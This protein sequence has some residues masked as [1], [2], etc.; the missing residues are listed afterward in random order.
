MQYLMQGALNVTNYLDTT[1]KHGNENDANMKHEMNVEH[2]DEFER[3]RR[4]FLI[5]PSK[6]ALQRYENQKRE[7]FE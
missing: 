7:D 2:Q 6:K 1:R 4:I 5:Y 3:H